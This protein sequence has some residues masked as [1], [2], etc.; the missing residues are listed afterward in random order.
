MTTKISQPV[1]A[2]LSEFVALHFGLHFPRERWHDLEREVCAAAEECG[3]STKLDDYLQALFSPMRTSEQTEVLASHLTIGETYFFREQRSLEV[4]EGRLM[5]ELIRARENRGRHIRI[6]SAGCATGEEPYSLAILLN[7]LMAGLK[8]WNLEI[9]AT[10]VNTKSLRKASAGIYSDW[11]FRGTPPWVRRTYFETRKDG[12][13][14]IAPAIRK[15]VSLSHLNLI[16]D[17]YRALPHGSSGFDVIFC[18]N[19]LMYFNPDAMR[20][21]IAQIHRSL[22]PGGW[23]IVSPTETS[24]EMFSE[25]SAVSFGDVTF[26]Q[27]S[28]HRVASAFVF[29]APIDLGPTQESAESAPGAPHS[30]P[31]AICE[32]I[33]KDTQSTPS[34]KTLPPITGYR[35]AL[36]LYEQGRYEDAQRALVTLLSH[37]GNHAP[38][39][40]LLARSYANQRKLAEAL[41][42]CDKAIAADKMEARAHYLRATILEEQGSIPEV[43]FALTQTV[44]AEPQFVLGHF[45]LGNLALK[46]GRLEDS[47]KHFENVLL[48]LAHYKPDDIV[49]ES[50]G[51]SAARLREM[52]IRPGNEP[53]VGLCI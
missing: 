4:F 11:S 26:Y 35:E 28:A 40:L 20:K 49:P 39:M 46:Q 37:D 45:S 53:T 15:M 30:A 19:V 22:E 41:A 10:D 5:P 50:E 52:I 14:M 3:D 47:E 6:W 2:Q 34:L 38:A 18:R 13:S 32:L 1:L 23:L 8:D 51:M 21:V 36:T 31:F 25:F 12:R 43:L 44:Y 16:D 29:P 48:L 33:R 7:R 17:V 42:W 27:K 9:L 24:Q